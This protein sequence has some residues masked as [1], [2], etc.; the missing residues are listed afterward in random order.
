MQRTND[1]QPRLHKSAELVNSTLTVCFSNGPISASGREHQFADGILTSGGTRPTAANPGTQWLPER[2]RSP[3]S[4]QGRQS[5]PLARGAILAAASRQ[6]FADPCVF[7]SSGIDLKLDRIG[8]MAIVRYRPSAPLDSYVE[9]LWWSQRDSPQLYREHM[10][11][12]TSTQLIFALQDGAYTWQSKSSDETS[13]V[14]TRGVVHGPQWSY[15][16][17]GPKPCG[18]VAGVSLRTGAA[19]TVLGVP[20]TELTD[21]HISIDALWGARGRS[22]HQ[23]LLDADAPMAVLRALEQELMSR[24]TRPLL[25]HPA[26]AHALADPVQG[27]GFTRISNVQRQAGYSPKHFITLFRGAVG[28]TPKH[29]YRVKR[30]TAALQAIAGGA[31][32][33]LA[34]LAASLGYADQSHLTREFRDLAGIT[35]TQYRPRGPDSVLHHMATGLPLRGP[36]GGKNSSRPATGDV[37]R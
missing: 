9:W 1:I 28:L 8:S 30:F 35:P 6:K 32:S 25:I 20:I 24:L 19:G 36:G 37:R 18:V 31:S 33:S 12:S 34:E 27:W 15:F 11:P 16:V 22:M 26:I 4:G 3:T 17:S 7:D 21:R 2:A 23:R 13:T 14:W 10:L 5:I 29:Y